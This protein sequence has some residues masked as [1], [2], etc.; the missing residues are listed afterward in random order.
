MRCL[1]IA[2][3]V[4]AMAIA[5]DAYAQQF[6]LSSRDFK[7]EGTL[8]EEHAYDGFGCKG[9]NISPHLSWSAAPRDARSFAVLVH[10]P[11]APTGGAG[12]WHWV[13][14]N[15]PPGETELRPDAGKAD[16]SRL[17]RGAVQ[18]ATD[19]GTPGWGGPC[20][21]PGDPPHRYNFTVYALTVDKL[22]LPPDARAS[23]AGFMVNAHAMGRAGITARY[24]RPR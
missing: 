2:T 15:I 1:C 21:P 24:G 10:D 9:K 7:P 23:L 6:R 18:I 11:D 19:Y 22:D 13:V 4:V 8:A 20:P 3:F 12:W 14:L 5:P 16:G 17:P